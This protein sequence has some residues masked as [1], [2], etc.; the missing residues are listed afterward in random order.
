MLTWLI[1]AGDIFY[2]DGHWDR[3]LL[4]ELHIPRSVQDA[5]QQRTDRLSEDARRVLILA[6]VAG[7]RFDFT[8]LQQLTQYDESHLLSLINELIAAQL[9]VEVSWECFA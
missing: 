1:R 2:V 7:R 5:V 4:S 8:L 3:K 9:L 6:A